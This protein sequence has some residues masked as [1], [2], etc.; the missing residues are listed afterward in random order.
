MEIQETWKGNG[1]ETWK[2]RCFENVSLQ[3]LEML[4]LILPALTTIA[5]KETLIFN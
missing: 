1:N 2:G 3:Y 5:P 4:K